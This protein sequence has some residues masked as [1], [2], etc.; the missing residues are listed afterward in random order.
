METLVKSTISALARYGPDQAANIF[1]LET[2]TDLLHRSNFIDFKIPN[3]EGVEDF[4]DIERFLRSILRLQQFRVQQA[5]NL[6]KDNS[7]NVIGLYAEAIGNLSRCDLA[8]RGVGFFKSVV[9]QCK[10]DMKIYWKL[11]VQS[12][13]KHVESIIS[14]LR[15]IFTAYKSNQLNKGVLLTINSLFW[16]YFQINQFQQCTFLI[17]PIKD[18]IDTMLVGTEKSYILTFYYYFGKL[19]IFEGQ[20]QQA[21]EYMERAFAMCPA[22]F[23]RHK[24]KI[25]KL[26]IPFKLMCGVMPSKQLIEHFG[27]QE[28]SGIIEAI[29]KGDLQQFEACKKQYKKQWIKRGI[30]FLIDSLELRLIRRLFKLVWILN[31]KKTIVSTELFQKALNFRSD[32]KMDLQETEC[33]V[34]N[35]IMKGYIRAS[36]FPEQKK[37]VFPAENAFPP[38]SQNQTMA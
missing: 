3:L 28:Y 37:T 2:V 38:L 9:A 17:R 22:K 25:L 13:D 6:F 36:V 8:M 34:G 21:A 5:A 30:Y 35:L 24:V 23:R 31:G 16:F 14:E 27:L 7:S 1:K 32:E 11:P 26:L 20:H 12:L 29:R 19:K 15:T 18:Q 4:A 10:K 33:L